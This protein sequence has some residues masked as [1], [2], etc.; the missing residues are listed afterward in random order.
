MAKRH[1]RSSPRQRHG[2]FFTSN[3]SFLLR[4][5]GDF[6]RGKVA[7]DPFA[8]DGDLLKWAE[9]NGAISIEAYDLFPRN[10]WTALRDSLRDPPSYAHRF[11]ISNPPYLASNKN[12]D[13]TYY[14]QWGTDDLYKCHIMSL[15][16]DCEEGVLIL[17]S[18][19]LSES[20]PSARNAFFTRFNAR[21][22]DYYMY[23]V[24]PEATTGIVVLAFH[25]QPPDISRSFTLRIHRHETRSRGGSQTPT[26]ET[27]S[28]TIR[29]K[30]G[31]LW[32][33]D[34]FDYIQ[35]DDPL[36]VV[37]Y[38]EGFEGV[39]NTSIVISLLDHGK[40]PMGVHFNPGPPRHCPVSVFTNYQV[41]LPG[42]SLTADEQHAVVSMYNA[43]LAHFRDQ[44]RSLFLSN[45]M[46]AETKI[47]SISFAH[48]LL[49]RVVKEVLGLWEE[50]PPDVASLFSS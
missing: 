46:G 30:Y 18:N 31:W 40:H 21:V 17:P 10:D 1:T 9:N 33:D 34:F 4:D 43:K 5:Y 41:H 22:A 48:K 39:P 27:L 29:R 26:V 19:F 7:L 16:K 15:L 12:P 42:F 25:K 20:S 32:G 6:V 45:Y 44:Y 2:Q 28:I 14:M 11:L 23:Q 37:K 8:G 36:E 38:D 24:F 50:P 47:K 35:D 13:K 49:S 3:A